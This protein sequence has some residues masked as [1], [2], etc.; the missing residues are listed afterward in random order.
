[1]S[2]TYPSD[3]LVQSSSSSFSLNDYINNA[4][5]NTESIA[6][7][8]QGSLVV[9]V[10]K[11]ENGKYYVGE[12]RDMI[13]RF[14][15]HLGDTGA[16]WTKIHKPIELLD[17]W[18]KEN[19]SDE[20][21]TTIQYMVEYGIDNV[22]GG[23]YCKPKL[24][25]AD[26]TSLQRIVNAS[27]NQCFDCGG[28]HYVT[29]CPDLSNSTDVATHSSSE[30]TPELIEFDTSDPVL[31]QLASLEP[32]GFIFHPGN[33]VKIRRCNIR[34]QCQNPGHRT[35]WLDGAGDNNHQRYQYI[36]GQWVTNSTED[37]PWY[38]YNKYTED[39][40][41]GVYLRHIEAD[42]CWRCGTTGSHFMCD[43]TE[44]VNGIAIQNA[45]Q[46]LMWSAGTSR[47]ERCGR[48]NHVESDCKA[49]YFIDGRLIN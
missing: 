27:N 26:Q 25:D 8:L 40:E 11:L 32:A 10:L 28:D 23:L 24:S 22:R 5:D 43:K 37:H 30:P 12:T 3:G 17:F 2:N 13:R 48:S 34:E 49:G 7:S 29:Q 31:S 46:A 47:C 38:E 39:S 20:N 15:Q 45:N 35:F 1:M 18:E 4:S 33:T 44:T 9:Y 36:N 42:C 14:Q 6:E 41:I 16:A 19:K 21:T